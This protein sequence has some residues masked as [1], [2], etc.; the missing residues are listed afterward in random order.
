VIDAA[1]GRVRVRYRLAAGVSFHALAVGPKTGWLYLFGD[2]AAGPKRVLPGGTVQPSDPVVAVVDP[3]NGTVLRG[4]TARAAA[5]YDWYTYR[6]LVSGD[7]GTVFVS[8]HGTYTTGID[9]FAITGAVAHRCE[10]SLGPGRGCIQG[11][12]DVELYAGGLLA[13][14][15]GE[16]IEELDQTGTVRRMLST[17]LAGNHLME[18]VVDGPTQR[19]YAVGPCGY[20]GGVSVV[21]IRTGR[22]RVLARP[23]DTAVCGERSAL[24]PRSLLVVGNTAVTVPQ[25]GIPGFLLFLDARSGKV[26]RTVA[27]PS[28]PVDVLVATP[29]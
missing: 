2:R 29:R 14:T 19:L 10:P 11:H 16:Y 28:E 7:E 12:G 27:T 1:T 13:A 15:G 6:G 21:D 4:W 5:D 26:R 22:T 18:F 9:S 23:G 24:G 20:T 3:H 8:Y 25:A 17:R